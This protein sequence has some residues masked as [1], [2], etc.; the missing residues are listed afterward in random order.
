MRYQ[1]TPAADFF[2]K[3]SAAET[4]ANFIC[5]YIVKKKKKIGMP[6]QQF[7]NKMKTPQSV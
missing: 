2:Q 4:R 7:K 5:V 1:S 6:G 3:I